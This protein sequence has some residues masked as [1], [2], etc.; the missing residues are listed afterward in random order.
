[1]RDRGLGALADLAQRRF[2]PELAGLDHDAA[3][4]E[5]ATRPASST[6]LDEIARAGANAIGAAAAEQRH[7][8][9][10]SS[11]SRDGSADELVAI[12]AHQRERIVGIVDRRAPS[13]RRRARGPGRRPDRKAG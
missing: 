1:M 4:L 13:A 12:E 5:S 9:G 2:R 11:T 8:H 6:P 3:I 10:A 7:R